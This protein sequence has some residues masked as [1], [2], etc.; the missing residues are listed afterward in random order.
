MEEKDEISDEET[1]TAREACTE[2]LTKFCSALW[3]YDELELPEK[4]AK[5]TLE[6]NS[7]MVRYWTL[8]ITSVY[9]ISSFLISDLNMEKTPA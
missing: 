5:Q 7:K 3:Y 4:Y 2:R 6:Y 1:K 8:G 9:I